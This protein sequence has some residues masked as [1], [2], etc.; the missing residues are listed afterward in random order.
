ML[1]LNRLAAVRDRETIMVTGIYSRHPNHAVLTQGEERLQLLGC[2][3]SW[4]PPQGSRVRV[5]GELLQGK[6]RRLLVHDACHA[7]L[8]SVA[9]AC[10][11]VLK[12]GMTV[13]LNVHVHN[14]GEEQIARTAD[15]RV[16]NL[17][18]EELDER[19]Y[20]LLGELITVNPPTLVVLQA[21]P[22]LVP[23]LTGT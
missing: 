21:V 13:T 2:P 12:T 11:P 17:I 20:V 10:R 16:F 22:I 23:T 18:G 8:P 14:I 7:S 15:R 5:W 9:P 19:K 1:A 6:S 3:F 4:L